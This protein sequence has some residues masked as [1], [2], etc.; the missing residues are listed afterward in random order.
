MARA[1]YVPDRGDFVWLNLNPRT[2]HE[3]SGYRPALVLTP[4]TFNGKSGLCVVCPATSKP[5]GYPFEVPHPGADDPNTVILS[6]HVRCVDWRARGARFLHRVPQDV[7]DEVV[8][9]LDALIINPGP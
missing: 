7:L 9:R 3:Q 2:G 5:K 4:T 1:K 6:E 8:A